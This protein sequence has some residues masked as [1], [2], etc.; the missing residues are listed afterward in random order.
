MVALEIY[1]F[2]YHRLA[3]QPLPLQY[4]R[5]M[6]KPVSFELPLQNALS[7]LLLR[8]LHIV[9][10]FAGPRAPF[11]VPSWK[12]FFALRETVDRDRMRP[13]PVV[14]L[15]LAFSPQLSI[16]AVSVCHVLDMSCCRVCRIR[17]S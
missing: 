13:V 17:G 5:R 12:P 16:H 7:K 8:S 10:W 11:G 6:K 1:A 4:V 3:T 9:Y 14:F 15:R 2:R